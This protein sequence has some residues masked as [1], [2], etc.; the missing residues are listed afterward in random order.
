[1]TTTSKGPIANAALSKS[2]FDT[3][4]ISGN[5]SEE[6]KRL[7]GDIPTIFG[8]Y[9]KPEGQSYNGFGKIIKDRMV[10]TELSILQKAEEPNKLEGRAVLEIDVLQGMHVFC[11]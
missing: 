4:N 5:A 8:T 11:F 7:L 10:V 2:Y 9:F 3:S 1:M 6:I